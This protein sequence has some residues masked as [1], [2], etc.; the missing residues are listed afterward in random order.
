MIQYLYARSPDT[1]QV[2]CFFRVHHAIAA[3]EIAFS[4]LDF[5]YLISDKFRTHFPSAPVTESFFVTVHYTPAGTSPGAS[6]GCIADL[7]Q[8]AQQVHRSAEQL[9]FFIYCKTAPHGSPPISYSSENPPAHQYRAESHTW[10]QDP[11]LKVP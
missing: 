7:L 6:F 3:E 2:C 10:D 9:P 1:N 5:S 11:A 8:S 4:S